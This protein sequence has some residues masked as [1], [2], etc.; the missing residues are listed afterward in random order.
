MQRNPQ[1]TTVLL[2]QDLPREA[3][4]IADACASVSLVLR[5]PSQVADAISREDERRRHRPGYAPGGRDGTQR[6]RFTNRRSFLIGGDGPPNGFPTP[7][8]FER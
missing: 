1:P 8:D 2:D 6:V 3:G 4:D 5:L 7:I